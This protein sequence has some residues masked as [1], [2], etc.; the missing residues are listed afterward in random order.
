VRIPAVTAGWIGPTPRLYISVRNRGRAFVRAQ[1]RVSC[2]RG[3]IRRFYRVIMEMVPPG[4][5]AVLPVN[6][7]GLASGAMPCT[8]SLRT[9]TGRP[10]TWSGIV[11]LP[12][13]S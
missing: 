6:A 4:G 12:P 3:G 13:R 11:R 8:V 1:G 9:D 10:V 5:G 2:R 7:R